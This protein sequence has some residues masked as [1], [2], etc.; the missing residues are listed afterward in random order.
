MPSAFVAKGI[1]LVVVFCTR[2]YTVTLFYMQPEPMCSN[3][4]VC[5]QPLALLSHISP[6]GVK[7]VGFFLHSSENL[8]ERT[9]H[10]LVNTITC[11]CMN[12]HTVAACSRRRVGRTR[13]FTSRQF[14]RLPRL[15]AIGWLPLAHAPI[16][17]ECSV[18]VMCSECVESQRKGARVSA[19]A[20]AS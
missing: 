9:Q 11:A 12:M 13:L 14:S 5:L 15:T 1:Q 4:A 2:N 6:S 7:Y 3:A 19:H 20:L 17:L 8:E 16:Y 10:M 18:C